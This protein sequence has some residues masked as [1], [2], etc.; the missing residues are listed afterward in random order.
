MMRG[1]TPATDGVRPPSGDADVPAFWRSLGPPG[2]I[3]VHTHFMP[4]NVVNLTRP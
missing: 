1:M 3:D 4:D 2:L